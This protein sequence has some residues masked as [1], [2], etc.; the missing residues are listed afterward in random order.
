MKNILLQYLRY[1][2][3]ANERVVSFM[4]ESYAD[5]EMKSSFPTIRKTLYHI[6]DAQQAWVLRLNNQPVTDWPSKTFEG[7]FNE[8]CSLLVKASVELADWIELKEEI[9]LTSAIR[10]ESM[11]KVPYT[12]MVN[13]ILMHMCNH[14][15]FHRGQLITMLR[16][17][18]ETNLGST[19]LITFFREKSAFN[20]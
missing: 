15:T 18:G 17:A 6:W 5:I 9:F 13:E 10:Y 20:N 3:W 4:K 2:A 1:N 7:S 12:N 8:A 16:N 11:Q 19:D 14:A